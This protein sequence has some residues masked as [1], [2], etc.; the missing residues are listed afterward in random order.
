MSSWVHWRRELWMVSCRRQV[1]MLWMI[2]SGVCKNSWVV[3]SGVG[4]GIGTQTDLPAI[5]GLAA[6]E[7]CELGLTF[8]TCNMGAS[9]PLGYCDH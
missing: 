3:L 4:R 2:H 6:H 7:L 8:L 5:Y 9:L 1:R